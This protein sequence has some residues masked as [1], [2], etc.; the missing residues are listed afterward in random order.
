MGFAD[1]AVSPICAAFSD[2]RYR[3]RSAE[4]TVIVDI[5]KSPRLLKSGHRE[6]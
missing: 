2:Q 5:L 4:L 1:Y 3:R 6:N